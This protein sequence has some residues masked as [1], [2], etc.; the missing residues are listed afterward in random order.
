[1]NPS[2]LKKLQF[3]EGDASELN[4]GI[5]EEN[6]EK[7]KTCS[8]IFH[9]AAC[10]RFDDALKN[11]ILLNTRGT[12]E[13]CELACKIPGLKA[14]VHVSTAYIQ[15]KNTFVQEKLYPM[16]CDWRSYIKYAETYSMEML[17]WLTPKYV[18]FFLH[19]NVN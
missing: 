8:I 13:L 11:A 7:L 4:L 5:S 9:A 14:L 1:M 17:N 2:S 12:R 19:V 6:I 16:N 3:I 10:V 18:T 15:P